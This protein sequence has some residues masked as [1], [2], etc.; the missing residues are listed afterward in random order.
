M[1][2]FNRIAVAAVFLSFALFAAGCGNTKTA[3]ESTLAL[4][5]NGKVEQVVHDTLDQDYYSKTGLKDYIKEQV[6]SYEDSIRLKKLKFSRKG[7]VTMDLVFQDADTYR[8]FEGK[9]CF[10]GTVGQAMASGYDFDTDFV[11]IEDGE[12]ADASKADGSGGAIGTSG[13]ATQNVVSSDAATDTINADV[14]IVEE[15]F[16][17]KV[18]GDI[19]FVSAEG[20]KVLDSHTVRV[21]RD[22]P[23]EVV[24]ILYQ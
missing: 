8:S 4:K 18:P 11:P 13:N 21:Q 1:K 3:G 24:Y 15:D 16:I 9:S 12:S 7:K 23:D 22:D 5:K 17:V 10:S 6:S 19:T 14:F 2:K 20:T